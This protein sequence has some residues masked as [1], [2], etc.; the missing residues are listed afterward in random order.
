RRSYRPSKPPIWLQDYVT[1]SKGT[2]CNFP[3]SAHVNYNHLSPA[4]KRAMSVYSTVSEQSNFKEAA[5]DPKWIEAMQLELQALEDNNT[6]SIVGL[7]PGKKP[8][9]CR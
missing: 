5:S 2:K 4:Y 7:P 8:I 9:G 6:W 1:K 3:I